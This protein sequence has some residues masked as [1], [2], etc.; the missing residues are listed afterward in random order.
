MLL[1]DPNNNYPRYIGDVYISSPNFD[2]VNL[3]D[4]WKLV[5]EVA[6]PSHDTTQIAVEEFPILV[7]N[8]YKQSWSIKSKPVKPAVTLPSLINLPFYTEN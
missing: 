8:K 3:P 4:G 5:E 1:I 7:G 6:A 2:G